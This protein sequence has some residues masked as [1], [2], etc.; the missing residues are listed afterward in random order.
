MAPLTLVALAALPALV[1]A[2]PDVEVDDPTGC[3]DAS[4]VAPALA[5]E[6][7]PELAELPAGL[8][9]VVVTV[10]SA[11][12]PEAVTVRA[13]WSTGERLLD[14][15]VPIVVTDCP[16]VPR[17]VAVIV[18]RRLSDLPQHEWERRRP[19]PAP[20]P[21]PRAW[22]LGLG[23]GGDLGLDSASWAGRIELVASLG[24]P[25]GIRGVFGVTA[26]AA[27]PVPVGAGEAQLTAALVILG[28]SWDVA[29]GPARLVPTVQA[30]GGLQVASGLAFDE[31]ETD[32]LP[33]L[34]V[35]AELA[36]HSD[37]GLYGAV[38]VSVPVIRT[39]VSEAGTTYTRLEPWVRLHFAM[40]FAWSGLF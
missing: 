19:P 27:A 40:G 26:S 23:A 39:S 29:L 32:V 24:Q 22:R 5:A 35:A 1:G 14:R 36:V 13:S 25:A 30:M 6:L 33:A 3:V 4:A 31:T 18:A 17:L 21:P 7:P 8:F 11:P 38:G 37:L 16:T 9:R 2:L 12:T 10:V 20:S 28:A 34:R 15:T